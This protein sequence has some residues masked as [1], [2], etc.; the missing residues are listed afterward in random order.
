[1]TETGI[2]N[3]RRNVARAIDL[4]QL[5]LAVVACDCGSFRRAAEALSIKHNVLSRSISQLGRRVSIVRLRRGP[6][7]REA[8]LA[9]I[10]DAGRGFGRAGAAAALVAG[11][12]GTDCRGDVGAGREGD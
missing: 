9:L 8:S 12:Q 6:S 7:A 1:M 2:R 3:N 4:Q 5:R 10:G 11:R